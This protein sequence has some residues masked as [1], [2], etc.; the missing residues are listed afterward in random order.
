MFILIVIL[1]LLLLSF[2]EKKTSI[3]ALEMYV[4]IS[5]LATYYIS[6]FDFTVLRSFEAVKYAC[7]YFAIHSHL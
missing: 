2:L 6:F 5:R 7:R 4:W 3:A 1:L